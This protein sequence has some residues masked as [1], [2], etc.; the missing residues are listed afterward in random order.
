MERLNLNLK[1]YAY[2]SKELLE[3]INAIMEE[4]AHR[5]AEVILKKGQVNHR[6]YF[7]LSG[8]IKIEGEAKGQAVIP[9]IL[10]EDNFV[11]A[12]D[13]FFCGDP[14]E[15]DIIALEDV[16]TV[17]STREQL[18]MMGKRYEELENGIG[19]IQASYR[20]EYEKRINILSKMEP[21]EKYEWFRTDKPDLMRRLKDEDIWI[22]LN[23]SRNAY[24]DCKN[25]RNK[26]K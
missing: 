12:T 4:S 20:K 19:K 14:T 8:L 21:H 10:P 23:M 17:S 3:A 1:K 5:R 6:V 15:Y 25:G 11:I 2:F 26:G 18:L 16:K 22:Y 7:I 9:Y 13:S 24:Y